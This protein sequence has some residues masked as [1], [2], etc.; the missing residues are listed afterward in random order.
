MTPPSHLLAVLGVV[1]I[2][3]LVLPQLLR[4]LHLPF[5]TSLILVGFALAEIPG[6]VPVAIVGMHWASQVR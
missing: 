3:G 2:F 4:P 6:G 1:L 5:A